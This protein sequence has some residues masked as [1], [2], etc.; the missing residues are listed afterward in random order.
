MKK[1]KSLTYLK[2]CQSC[3]SKIKRTQALSGAKKP[4]YP[5][6]QPQNTFFEHY[7][8]TISNPMFKTH[9]KII[10]IKPKSVIIGI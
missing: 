4:V 9:T 10:L 6:T 7:T 5:R 2:P 1:L 8:Y 3:I